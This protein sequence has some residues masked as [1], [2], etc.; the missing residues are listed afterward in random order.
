MAE[1]E[2]ARIIDISVNGPIFSGAE[3]QVHDESAAGDARARPF[4]CGFINPVS[5]RG[6]PTERESILDENILPPRIDIEGGR[7]PGDARNLTGSRREAS[8]LL[9]AEKGAERRD[10]RSATHLH[11]GIRILRELFL[12]SRVT[13]VESR[14]ADEFAG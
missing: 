11:E 3:L 8:C 6:K 9:S 1:R 12:I 2:R 7:G 14:I 5:P 13:G 4:Y 10:P